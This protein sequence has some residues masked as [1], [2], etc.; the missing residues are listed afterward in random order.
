MKINNVE[1]NPA[2]I[3]RIEQDCESLHII[4]KD[5]ISNDLYDEYCSKLETIYPD[6]IN[7]DLSIMWY[8]ITDEEFVIDF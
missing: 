2:H 3:D 8:P 6:I 1:I 5:D 4:F 7:T